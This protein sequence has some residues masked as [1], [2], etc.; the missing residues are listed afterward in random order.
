MVKSADK[1]KSIHREPHQGEAAGKSYFA[2]NKFRKLGFIEYNEKLK[3]HKIFVEH[4][5]AREARDQNEG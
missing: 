2:S 3:V 4:G 5:S 1:P